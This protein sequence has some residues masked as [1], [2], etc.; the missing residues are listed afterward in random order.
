MSYYAEASAAFAF[1]IA[2]VNTHPLAELQKKLTCSGISAMSIL[3]L[4]KVYYGG[5]RVRHAGRFWVQLTNP[6][7][8]LPENETN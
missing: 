6:I 2:D 3:E 5:R 1:K 4:S 8:H 7:L